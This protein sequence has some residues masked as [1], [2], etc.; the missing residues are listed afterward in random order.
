MK[1]DPDISGV[2]RI[3]GTR[4]MITWP[5]MAASMKMYNAT[6]PSA[7]RPTPLSRRLH[8]NDP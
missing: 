2:C 1:L 8:H 4:E 3:T 6:N 5:A 7:M